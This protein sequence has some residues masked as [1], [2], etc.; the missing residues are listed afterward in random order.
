M[1]IVRYWT[2]RKTQEAV[3][4]ANTREAR[5]ERR[6]GRKTT[7][8]RMTIYPTTWTTTTRKTKVRNYTNSDFPTTVTR[9]F[10]FWEVL[11]LYK[12][13]ISLFEGCSFLCGTKKNKRRKDKRNEE[14]FIN[15]HGR[16][17]T[18]I[19]DVEVL[20]LTIK[21]KKGKNKWKEKKHAKKKRRGTMRKR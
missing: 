9:T 18:V 4:S 21:K 5:V 7:R 20:M 1:D 6:I 19:N 2:F 10:L 12:M 13:N 15:Y 11:V 16:T 3:V 14:S 17:W 8:R